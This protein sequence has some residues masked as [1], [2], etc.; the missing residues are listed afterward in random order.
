MPYR[1]LLQSG[2]GLSGT[3]RTLYR[4]IDNGGVTN[5]GTTTISTSYQ[6]KS[7]QGFDTPHFHKRKRKG[8]LLPFT[9]F[10]QYE[11]DG[12]ITGA[13]DVTANPYPDGHKYHYWTSPDSGFPDTSDPADDLLQVTQAELRALADD[14]AKTDYLVQHAA[15]SIYSNGFDA[16]TFV[17]EFHQVVAMFRG[18]VPRVL[19]LLASVKHYDDLLLELRYGWRPLLYDMQDIA[20]VMK[21][22]NKG[23]TRFLEHARGLYSDSTSTTID[24]WQTKVFGSISLRTDTDILVAGRGSIV[25]DIEPP[26]L[27]FNPFVTAWEVVTLSFVI[28]WIV[29]VGQWINSMSFLVL[30][31]KYVAAGGALVTL[32]KNYSTIYTP[33]GNF[34]GTWSVEGNVTATLVLRQPTSVS[35]LPQVKLKL[36]ELKV[37]D[38]LALLTQR[39]K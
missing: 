28:D 4:Q 38:L 20:K 18:F 9:P 34:Q 3:T 15:A 23:K 19:K 22:I 10:T 25:A 39:V 1:P 11:V 27:S 5:Q 17:A 2:A 37:L 21:R 16:L 13:L 12:T 30:Q 35:N 31:R 24:T 14:H 29:N 32:S 26:K 33:T 8:E 7:T 36:N 6:Y